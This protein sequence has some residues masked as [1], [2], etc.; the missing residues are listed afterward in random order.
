MCS[1]SYS[2]IVELEFKSG[3]F[4]CSEAKWT[5]FLLFTFFFFNRQ[6][7]CLYGAYIVVGE[8]DNKPTLK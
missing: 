1:R 6:A 8:T 5:H 4:Y 3:Q 2:W 7:F